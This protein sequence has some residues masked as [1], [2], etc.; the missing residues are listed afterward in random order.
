MECGELIKQYLL[1]LLAVFRKKIRG[2]K[3]TLS[4]IL[5]LTAIPD[6]GMDMTS[7]AEK[8]GVDNSTATRLID[9]M[10]RIGLIQKGKSPDD[11]RI[12]II[13]LTEKGEIASEEIET[14]LDIIGEDIFKHVPIEQKEEI[15]EA[16][17]TFHWSLLK[18][19]NSV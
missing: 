18:Y 9:G 1:S 8:I 12:T 15:K 10:V 7:L 17:L 5:I 16:L 14:K 4:Q 2:K 13:S 11:K 3:Y 6:Q 19:K